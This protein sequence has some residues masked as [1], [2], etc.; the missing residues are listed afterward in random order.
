MPSLVLRFLFWA[1]LLGGTCAAASRPT[2]GMLVKVNSNEGFWGEVARGA[3]EAAED[4]QVDLVVR[5]VRSVSNPG[6]QIKLLESFASQKIDALVITPTNAERLIAPLQAAAALGLKIVV[7]ESELA[8]D[9]S[10]PY[11]GYDQAG[12][13]AAAATAFASL[14]SGQDEVAI[15]RGVTD[16]TIVQRDK[17][18]LARLKELRPT[19]RLHLDFFAIT[20][21]SS[22]TA[23]KAA[24]LFQKHPGSR[25]FIGTGSGATHAMLAAARTAGIG[26]VKIAGFGFHLTPEVVQA[27]EEGTLQALVCQMPREMGYKS[28]ATAAALI[29]GEKVPPRTNISFVVVTRDNLNTPAV[30]ALRP[31]SVPA[32][33]DGAQQ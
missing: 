25:L 3:K 15:F 32:K 14:V 8:A 4:A 21:D 20:N 16:Q 1:T 17:I 13:A 6:A 10:F 23:E 29:R 24:L 12:L 19:L 30:Q 28:V 5:G 33:S 18:I 31:P 2:V 9:T 26:A 22:T 27:I 11:V 7:A